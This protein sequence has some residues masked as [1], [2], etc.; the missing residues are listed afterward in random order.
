MSKLD[1]EVK[2]ITWAGQKFDVV[3]RT[4]ATHSSKTHST[5]SV[6]QF[7]TDKWEP[8]GD[9]AIN[10]NP[11]ARKFI[12][13]AAGLFDVN[14]E[15]PTVTKWRKIANGYKFIDSEPKGYSL[16]LWPVGGKQEQ[17]ARNAELVAEYDRAYENEVRI[18]AEAKAKALQIIADNADLR[19]MQL[20]VEVEGHVFEF[21]RSLWSDGSEYTNISKL[22]C[23][24]ESNRM[25]Q[26]NSKTTFPTDAERALA[27]FDASVMC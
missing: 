13:F 19:I 9:I 15:K 14:V 18:E 3:L 2:T 1:Y 23:N 17:E 5:I 25:R 10:G 26:Y 27:G 16:E 20:E 21:K 7:A 24:C 6:K 12:Q 22:V 4:H 11:A 8:L